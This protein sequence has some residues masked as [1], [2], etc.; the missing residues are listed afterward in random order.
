MP[1]KATAAAAAIASRSAALPVAETMSLP[2][3][4]AAT[5]M[6]LFDMHQRL[7]D[8]GDWCTKALNHSNFSVCK[9]CLCLDDPTRSRVGC[10]RSEASLIRFGGWLAGAAERIPTQSLLDGPPKKLAVTS[11]LRVDRAA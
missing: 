3:T 1:T 10:R 7:A 6:L 9:H 2:A 11:E 4:S 5:V 8:R